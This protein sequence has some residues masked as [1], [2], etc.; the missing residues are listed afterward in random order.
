GPVQRQGARTD[1][2][3]T[4][5]PPHRRTVLWVDGAGCAVAALGDST[6]TDFLLLAGFC[7]RFVEQLVP[8]SEGPTPTVRRTADRPRAP[9]WLRSGPAPEADG[10]QE[11]ERA[12]PGGLLGE[13]LGA[14]LQER[15]QV[16]RVPER[17]R[18][19]RGVV[20]GAGGQG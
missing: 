2:C 18:D 13:L 5:V 3:A 17:V 11:R 15:D 12:P 1:P 6:P 8:W 14:K 16:R 20:A 4:R 19:R 7:P 10:A 9:G